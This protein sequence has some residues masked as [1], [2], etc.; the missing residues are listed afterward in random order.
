MWH[1]MFCFI[2]KLRYVVSRECEQSVSD[3]ISALIPADRSIHSSSTVLYLSRPAPAHP[4]FSPLR[5]H[6]Q[7]VND[8][9]FCR[10]RAF[11]R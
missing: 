3:E 8:L 11:R 1:I 4:I 2:L 10:L 5:S 7:V 6:S 9:V